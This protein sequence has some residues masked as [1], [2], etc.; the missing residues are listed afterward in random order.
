M[1]DPTPSPT[2]RALADLREVLEAVG[3][4]LTGVELEGLLTAEERIAKAV[5]DVRAATAARPSG[6]TVVE[7]DTLRSDVHAVRAALQRCRRLGVSLSRFASFSLTAA[8]GTGSYT[9]RGLSRAS[10]I[11]ERAVDTRV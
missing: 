11:S 8:A 10:Q 4:A 2:S 3:N 6:D 1:A 7:R 9:R 5:R